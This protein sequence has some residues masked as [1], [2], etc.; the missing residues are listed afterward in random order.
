[1]ATWSRE[2]SRP[3]VG[4]AVERRCLPDP[5]EGQHPGETKPGAVANS[6]VQDVPVHLQQEGYPGYLPARTVCGCWVR[7][8]HPGTPEQLQQITGYQVKRI[9]HSGRSST[10]G[11]RGRS[12][13]VQC[14]AVAVNN[15]AV[16]R[17][18]VRSLAS[19][20]AAVA[21]QRRGVYAVLSPKPGWP[22]YTHGPRAT[23]AMRLIVR[24]R[25]HRLQSPTGI[26]YRQMESGAKQGSRRG[27]TTYRGSL[28]SA[29]R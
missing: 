20:S 5:S 3:P 7:R 14:V 21:G 23:P 11:P 25:R 9:P 10:P 19:E 28:L 27:D 13:M 6:Q 22:I 29:A 26:R 17:R 4:S 15:R 24:G 2:A 1:M 18:H 8:I 16:H 12:Q